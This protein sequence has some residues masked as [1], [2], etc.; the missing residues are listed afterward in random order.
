[1]QSNV[2]QT[3]RILVADKRKIQVGDK[4]A[5]RHGNK[6]VISK[7][8]RKENM[9]YLEDGTIVDI[10]FN[11]LGVPS[12]MNVGQ[13]FEAELGLIASKLKEKIEAYAKINDFE[14]IK[15]I[16]NAA[17]V[18]YSDL[19]AAIQQV[20]DHGIGM[21]VMPFIKG[22]Q[23]DITK[24]RELAETS[25]DG[26]Y[27]LYDGKTGEAY[28]NKITVGK[29]YIMR[30]N[31]DVSDKIHARST[32][33]YA[34]IHQQPLGGRSQAGGQKL[35]EMEQW[36][37][38]AYGAAYNNTEIC[39]KSDDVEGRLN[40]YSAFIRGDDR[41]TANIPESFKMFKMFVESL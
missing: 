37:L 19:S 22:K 16:F 35:G 29:M 2:I 27:K 12:R 7:I 18:E 3:A 32:G 25:I 9:P 8:E 34:L 24:L 23:Q 17:N 21:L 36:A 10:I 5:G 4:V 6:C 39:V 14:N 15:K 40:A 28:A 41:F 20:L 26:Q 31:H 33:P 13:I 1:M 30:L 11:S 38:Q